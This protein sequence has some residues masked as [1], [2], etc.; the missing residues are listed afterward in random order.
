MVIWV[1]PSRWKKKVIVDFEAHLNAV[2]RSLSAPQRD[3]QDTRSVRLTRTFATSLEYLWDAVT[4]AERIPRWF[5]LIS[6][7][8]KLD[9]RYQFE[10]NTGG[11]I[12]QCEPP[13]Y[14]S[15]TWK[16]GDDVSWVDV[17]FEV[18]LVHWTV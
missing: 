9:G 12:T 15:V 7:D 4:N 11:Q 8:L 16:F 5:V 6:G 10:A 18:V 2:E 1:R 3:E 13:S 17:R 14:L